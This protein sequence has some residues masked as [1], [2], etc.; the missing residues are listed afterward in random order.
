[1][2]ETRFSKSGLFLMELMVVILLFAISGAICL[3]MFAYASQTAKNAQNLR[4]AT[5]SAK[6][7]A[8]CHNATAGDLEQMATL[9]AGTATD[10]GLEIGYDDQ[11]QSV[12]GQPTYILTLTEQGNTALISV[13][14][15][16]D[17]VIYTLTIGVMG[18]G[19]S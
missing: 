19:K 4:N 3:Q 2:S 13:A 16:D 14:S 15:A 18:G 6:S 8:E 9:L 11:W 7:V 10:T 5:M 1:M 17:Q 12:D